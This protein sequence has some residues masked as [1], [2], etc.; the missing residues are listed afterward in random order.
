[1]FRAPF[2]GGRVE[3][4]GALT[5]RVWQRRMV[6]VSIVKKSKPTDFAWVSLLWCPLQKKDRDASGLGLQKRSSRRHYRA[7]EHDK[8]HLK[9]DVSFAQY[10]KDLSNIWLC[11]LLKLG[12]ASVDGW[13]AAAKIPPAA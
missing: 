6:E 8:R 5:G 4:P 9:M 10:V 11:T 7:G 1:M 2:S 3:L 13:S 12:Q